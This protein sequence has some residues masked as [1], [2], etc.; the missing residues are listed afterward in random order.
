MQLVED[1]AQPKQYGL[2][3]PQPWLVAFAHYCF[4]QA[5]VGI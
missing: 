1:P 5:I 4:L 3:V 2:P